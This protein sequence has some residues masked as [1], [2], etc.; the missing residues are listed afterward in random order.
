MLYVMGIRVRAKALGIPASY[1]MYRAWD[2][3]DRVRVAE[4][5]ISGKQ[6]LSIVESTLVC[7]NI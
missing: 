1:E 4:R 2:E 7:Q 6:S 3:A 5:R